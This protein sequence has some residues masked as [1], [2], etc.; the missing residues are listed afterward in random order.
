MAYDLLNKRRT[1]DLRVHVGHT[2]NSLCLMGAIPIG[3]LVL[4]TLFNTKENE[5]DLKEPKPFA[6][7]NTLQDF[8]Y[9]HRYKCL[10]YQESFSLTFRVH[11]SE[12]WQNN[13]T[14][15]DIVKFN[16]WIGAGNE[17]LRDVVVKKYGED[18]AKLI[19]NLL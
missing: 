16:E 3:G 19:Q 12:F 13:L 10:K 4:K 11:L 5:M 14:G 8:A 9:Y 1:M 18:A 7:C 2:D 15:F 17:C 6:E